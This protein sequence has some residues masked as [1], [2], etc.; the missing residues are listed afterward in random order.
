MPCRSLA[1]PPLRPSGRPSRLILSLGVVAALGAPALARADEAPPL[2]PA[3]IDTAVMADI[4]AIFSTPVVL[5]SIEAHN[6]TY[7]DLTAEEIDALDKQ[8]RRERDEDDQPLIAATL[9]SP[10]SSYLTQI[11]AASAGLYTELFVMDANGLNVGQSAITSDFW[12]GD[13]AKF[14]KSYAIGPT[15]VF[16]DQAEYNDE[17]GTWRAQ[18]NLTVADATGGALGAA[19]A[20]VNLTELARRRATQ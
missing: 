9:S 14:Q 18:V 11:Q 17:T 13:E 10:L 7:T 3:L 12:Q 2:S 8:W 20:E 15:A 16:V 6:R 19:T 1:P 5:M 4:R